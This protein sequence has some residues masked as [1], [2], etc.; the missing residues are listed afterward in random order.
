MILSAETISF[1]LR[2]TLRMAMVWS[3]SMLSSSTLGISATS[4]SVF[5]GTDTSMIRSFL[6]GRILMASAT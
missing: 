3:A 2:S 6:S 4:S 1:L 5:L